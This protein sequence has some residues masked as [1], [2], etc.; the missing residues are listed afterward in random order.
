MILGNAHRLRQERDESTTLG[1]FEKVLDIFM[2]E[3]DATAIDDPLH[4]ELE[5]KVDNLERKIA[6]LE[7]ELTTAKTKLAQAETNAQE[8]AS[9]SDK[10]LLDVQKKLVLNL[11][12]QLD[13]YRSNVLDY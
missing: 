4:I 5:G 3:G 9:N 2:N 1:P 12:S 13:E 8:N 10:E 7:N 6:A 11:E